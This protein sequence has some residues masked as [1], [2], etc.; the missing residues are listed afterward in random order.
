MRESTGADNFPLLMASAN[1]DLEQLRAV[2][3]GLSIG[4]LLALTK[5]VYTFPRPPLS[6]CSLF[7]IP[8]SLPPPPLSDP[9]DPNRQHVLWLANGVDLDDVLTSES[10]GIRRF[11]GFACFTVVF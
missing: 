8:S 1:F 2:V 4:I 6:P 11:Q 3:A 9:N 7:S 5:C 10:T